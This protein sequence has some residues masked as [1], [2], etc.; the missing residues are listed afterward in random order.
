M[1]K[2][3]PCYRNVQNQIASDVSETYNP[4]HKLTTDNPKLVLI[5]AL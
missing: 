5:N 1:S 4:V 2:P 3:M